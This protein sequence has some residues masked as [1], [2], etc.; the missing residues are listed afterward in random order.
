MLLYA[1]SN[2]KKKWRPVLAAAHPYNGHHLDSCH[3]NKQ[4]S[5][6]RPDRVR[7][8]KLIAYSHECISSK[9]INGVADKQGRG[10]YRYVDSDSGVL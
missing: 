1:D 4:L 5:R 8:R 10:A 3:Y 9:R 7:S 6:N 2:N